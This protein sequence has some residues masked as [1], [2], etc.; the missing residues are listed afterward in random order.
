MRSPLRGS[1]S[2]VFNA[3]PRLAKPRLGLNSGPASQLRTIVFDATHGSQSFALGLTLAAAS[4]L[5]GKIVFTKPKARLC[6]PW[7]NVVINLF[8]AAERRPKYL[9]TK[10]CL[11]NLI[12]LPSPIT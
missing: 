10:I 2:I 5:V 4:R 7:V 1:G 6:E 11:T 12:A 3:T 9:E 8:G